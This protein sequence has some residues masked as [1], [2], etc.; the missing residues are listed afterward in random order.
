MDKT[1]KM[2]ISLL[3]GLVFF[4]VTKEMIISLIICLWLLFALFSLSHQ[5]FLFFSIFFFVSYLVFDNIRF[6][7]PALM[8]ILGLLLAVLP[9][10][11]A[12]ERQVPIRFWRDTKITGQLILVVFFVLALFFSYQTYQKQQQKQEVLTEKPPEKVIIRL[13]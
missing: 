8:V 10:S 13:K 3:G 4:I 5:I 1:T 12:K 7:Y 6:I 9:K 11:V 2:L